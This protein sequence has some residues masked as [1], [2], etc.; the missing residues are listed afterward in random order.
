MEFPFLITLYGK[1]IKTRII[2]ASLWF[3]ASDIPQKHPVE[4]ARHKDYYTANAAP[5][6]HT[7]FERLKLIF[8]FLYQ[9]R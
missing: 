3:R 4:V 7:A 5:V 9:N 8:G 2:G 1:H 6:G